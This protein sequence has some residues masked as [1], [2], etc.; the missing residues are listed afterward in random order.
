MP[1]VMEVEHTTGITSGLSRMKNF[2]DKFPPFPTRY[3]IVAPDEDR[4]KVLQE[5]NKEQFRDLNPLYFPYSSVEELYSLCQRRK[6]KGVT[7]NFLD[8]FMEQTL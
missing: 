1:A 4:H 2:K 7:E 8:C 5:C 6:L 3:V